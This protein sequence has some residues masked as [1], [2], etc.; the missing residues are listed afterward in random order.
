ML[1]P[2]LQGAEGCRR[3]LARQRGSPVEPKRVARI[4]PRHNGWGARPAA[5][6]STTTVVDQGPRPRQ[7]TTRRD[8]NPPAPDHDV[9]W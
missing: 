4:M 7:A 3:W 2:P 1:G 8:F 9:G 6:R 5:A